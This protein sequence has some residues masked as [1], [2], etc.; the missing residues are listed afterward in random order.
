MNTGLQDAF[1]L[2]WKLAL[3]C[4]GVADA[5]LLDS[6]EAE[7]RPVAEMVARSGDTTEQ[8]EMITGEGQRRERDAAIRATFVEPV[9]RHNEIVS[10]TEL[11]V[12][13]SASPI[14]FGGAGKVFAAGERVPNTIPIHSTGHTLVLV[15]DTT[16]EELSFASL[17]EALRKVVDGSSVFEAV[18]SLA[19]SHALD[20][21]GNITILAV[22]PDGYVGMRCERDHVVALE[23]Y[24]RVITGRSSA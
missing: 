13:Y 17:C 15:E 11:N 23:R 1:N 8:G 12:E 7:R 21:P 2:A 14:V 20:A 24:E 4:N 10:E 3:V 9:S 18:V 16:S 22:R 6:Y 5:A 19:W